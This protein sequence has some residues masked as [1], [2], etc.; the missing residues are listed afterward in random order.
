[1]SPQ[2]QVK[3]IHHRIKSQQK[4]DQRH[5][6]MQ[7]ITHQP[8]FTQS[9]HQGRVPQQLSPQMSLQVQPQTKS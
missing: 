9:L 8:S 3:S 5:E 7:Q 6:H 4:K 1:M 2:R